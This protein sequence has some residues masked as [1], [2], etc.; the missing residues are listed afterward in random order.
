MKFKDIQDVIEQANACQFGLGG[1]VWTKDL[2]LG[3]QIAD[4]L[5]TG[6]VWINRHA[7]MSPNAPFC[8]WKMSGLGYAFAMSGLLQFTK[9]QA[10]HISA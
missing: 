9:K 4:Q 6:T 2:E 3:Q 7:Q 10:V 5:E 1:S 8:G